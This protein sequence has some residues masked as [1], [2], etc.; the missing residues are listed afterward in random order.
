M[1]GEEF[2]TP[3]AMRRM[4]RSAGNDSTI[5]G[6]IVRID[7]PG[8]DGFASD[9]I[10]REMMLLRQ[11]KPLVISMSDTAASGGYYIAMTGDPVLAYPGTLTGSIGVFYGKVDLHGLYDKLGITKQLLSRGQFAEIDSDYT[12]L[13]DAGRRKMQ[14][15]IDQF[16]NSFIGR[17]AQGRRRSPAQIEPVAQGRV[18]LGD[19]ARLNGLV[20]ELGGLDRA[21][22]TVKQ[23]AGIPRE[24]KIRLVSYPPR[25][26]ILDELFGRAQA[27]ATPPMV[28]FLRRFATATW[29]RGGFLELMPYT[30]TIE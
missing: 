1:P 13:S 3:A 25:R 26:S 23:K 2:M 19:Q 17:V 24:E 12:P 20:D 4:L 28:K 16:Y 11:K 7:S 29:M 15:S 6:V 21:I 8:G 10:W 27:E 18:W 14:D 5:K 30:I 9:E 22:E